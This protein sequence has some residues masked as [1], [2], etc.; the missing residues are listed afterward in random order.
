[1]RFP[2]AV[3]VLRATATDAYGNPG[4]SWEAPTEIPAA[5]FVLGSGKAMFPPA[6]DLRPGDRVRRDGR[7]FAVEDLKPVRSPSRTVLL[8]AKLRLL[9][10]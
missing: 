10:A 7:V 3:T 6:T 1:M 8:S 9:E 4:A 2:D 5:A